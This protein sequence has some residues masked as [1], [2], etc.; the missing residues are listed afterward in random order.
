M[1]I[2][3]PLGYGSLGQIDLSNFRITKE[4][5][6]PA[7]LP[8]LLSMPPAEAQTK[9]RI[10]SM[11][12]V[13]RPADYNVNANW[14]AFEFEAQI[15]G[16]IRGFTRRDLTTGIQQQCRH[17]PFDGRRSQHGAR[18]HHFASSESVMGCHPM[19]WR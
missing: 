16:A 6:P 3:S 17:T 12:T 14:Y 9:R 5:K 19:T 4:N 11:V 15:G 10:H 1:N 7:L 8:I 18:T 2:Y 13:G